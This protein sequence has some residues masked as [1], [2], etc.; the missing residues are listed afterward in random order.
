LVK[1]EDWLGI[2]LIPMTILFILTQKVF[3][4]N[5]WTT[6][7]VLAILF[8]KIIISLTNSNYFTIYGANDDAT[9]FF[10]DA[11]SITRSNITINFLSNGAELYKN[12]LAF[13]YNFS[14]VSKFTGEMLSILVFIISISYLLKIAQML[15]GSKYNAYLVSFFG[16]LPSMLIYT[17][18]TMRE[19]YQI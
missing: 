7:S 12:F 10:Q 8:T 11:A 9:T 19:P 6:I 3:I 17:S 13:I 1:P 5:L 4:K 2:V 14:G 18:I 16:F 15:Y